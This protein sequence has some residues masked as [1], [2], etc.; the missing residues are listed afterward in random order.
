METDIPLKDL[1]LACA[2]D[3]L[4]LLGSPGA[5]L[6][7]AYSLELP[8]SASRLDTVLHLRSP[9][10]T[11][12]LHLVEWQGYRD[13]RFLQRV[14]YYWIW[15]ILNRTLPVLVTIVYLKPGDDTGDT[16]RLVLDGREYFSVPFHRVRLWQE[17]AATAIASGRPGLAVL[18]ALMA[19]SNAAAVEE[20]AGV[21]LRAEPDPAK[22]A[23]LLGILGVFAE[24]FMAPEQLERILGRERL[25]ESKLLEYLM[26]EKTAEFAQ[27]LAE[28]RAEG[29]RAEGERA[30]RER[31][32]RVERERERERVE[33][34]RER[35]ER[36]RERERVEREREQERVERERTR[37]NFEQAVEDAMI[38]RFPAA[39]LALAATMREIRDPEQLLQ[40]HRAILTAPDQ[41]AAERAIRELTVR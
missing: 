20:A 39:P 17:D 23:S 32:E 4:A 27:R 21:V 28:A 36:E 18:S 2:S 24:A 10:G 13:P 9:L 33:Q 19:G 8:A 3:L 30:E 26:R 25:M 7:E 6:I 35:V 31:V 15:L 29:E 22:Q 14:L 41:A 37:R 16:F 1:T 11:E 38:A 12:Y 5:T 34:E 40:L